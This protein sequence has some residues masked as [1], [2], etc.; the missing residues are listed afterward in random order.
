MR[1]SKPSG[2]DSDKDV[3]N[4][5]RVGSLADFSWWVV[6]VAWNFKQPIAI[7]LPVSARVAGMKVLSAIALMVLTGAAAQARKML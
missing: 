1:D 6:H 3:R 7:P 4:V 2:I 5:L